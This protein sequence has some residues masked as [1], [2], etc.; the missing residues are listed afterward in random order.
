MRFRR[1]ARV[2][3][4]IPNSSMS[5]IAFLLL[6]FF[7]V[8]TAFAARKGIDF[9]LPAPAKDEQEIEEKEL[10]AITIQVLAS[11]RLVIDGSPRNV[12]DIQP[13]IKPVLA[14]DPKKFVIIQMDMDATYGNMMEVLDE[15][16]LA[17][18]QNIALP[19]KQEMTSW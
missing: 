6:I 13:Y 7:M 11:G 5:D 16:K 8:T 15:L 3:A 10:K 18:V 4:E 14:V 12:S 19:S 9:R 17:E 2:E 1:N